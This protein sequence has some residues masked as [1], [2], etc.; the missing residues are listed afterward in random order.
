MLKNKRGIQNFVG[1]EGKKGEEG[2]LGRQSGGGGSSNVTKGDG[3]GGKKKN[4]RNLSEWTLWG[5]VTGRQG[6]R[7]RGLDKGRTNWC[8]PK[9]KKE[10]KNPK[11]PAKEKKWGLFGK[12]EEG[13]EAGLAV[14]L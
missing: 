12:K 4:K 14:A 7:G 13:A 8:D 10:K 3:S 5:A 6:E 11:E 2:K 9:E 1:G